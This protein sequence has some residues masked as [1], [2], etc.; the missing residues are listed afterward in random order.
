MTDAVSAFTLTLPAGN[1]SMA[2]WIVNCPLGWSDVTLIK[3]V[4]PP[5]PAGNVGV[6]VQYSRNWVYP[7]TTGTFFVADD[8]VIDIPVTNQQQAGQWTLIG[9]N[10]DQ[11]VHS[12]QGWF[13]YNYVLQEQA[14]TGGGLVSL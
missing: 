8:Y 1:G 3:L 7:V 12:I 13:Y 14:D 10:T 4:F 9:Y 2:E 11:F 5:G 6:A